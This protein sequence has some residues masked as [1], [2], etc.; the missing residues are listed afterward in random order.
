MSLVA[1]LKEEEML[2]DGNHLVVACMLKDN[3]KEI[4]FYI[5]IDDEATRYAF[6]NEDFARCQKLSLYKL[7]ESRGLEIFD[8]RTTSSEDITHIVKEHLKIEQHTETLL[9]FV[10]KLEHYLMMLGNPWLKRHDVQIEFKIDTVM[11]GSDYCLQNCL[12]EPTMVK[13]ITSPLPEYQPRVTMVG[14]SAFSRMATTGQRRHGVELAGRFTVH[15]LRT[16]LRVY[17]ASCS[18][19]LTSTGDTDNDIRS[20]IPEELHNLI[21]AFRKK[22]ADKLPPHRPHD[23]KIELKEGFEPSFGSLYKLSRDEL[24]TL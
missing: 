5:M 22:V 8:G 19:K 10:T 23:L 12:R 21:H 7:K 9:F 13:G 4:F 20:K 16:A 11:F 3:E 15:E 14:S 2:K 24:T 6:M 18:E 17:A 1:L